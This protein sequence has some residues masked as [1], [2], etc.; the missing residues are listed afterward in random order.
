MPT[1]W[2]RVLRRSLRDTVAADDPRKRIAAVAIAAAVSGVGV[3]AGVRDS[4]EPLQVLVF[5]LAGLGL[6]FGVLWLTQLVQAPSRI[7]HDNASEIQR[8]SG[9]LA[10]L[11]PNAVSSLEVRISELRRK[12]IDENQR[13]KERD[14]WFSQI[15]TDKTKWPGYE[16][17]LAALG[18]EIVSRDHNSGYPNIRFKLPKNQKL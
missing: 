15:E 11:T 1:Y 14:M 17:A 5:G 10:K 18:W 12:A 8:L 6:F 3:L 4:G 2:K 13:T 9:E 7:D 16:E